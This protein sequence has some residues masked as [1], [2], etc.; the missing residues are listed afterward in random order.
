MPMDFS[1]M[2]LGTQYNYN[3]AAQNRKSIYDDMMRQRQQQDAMALADQQSWNRQ[4]ETQAEMDRRNKYEL[5]SAN[6]KNAATFFTQ[7]MNDAQDTGNWESYKQN[8][9][10][11]QKM[12]PDQVPALTPETESSLKA[13]FE[14]AASVKKM[15]RGASGPGDLIMFES[16]NPGFT[17]EKR[18]TPEYQQAYDAWVGPYVAKRYGTNQFVGT[19]PNDPNKNI[20][21]NTRTG[22]TSI[23]AGAGPAA[24]KELTAPTSEETTK[25][26]GYQSA[27]E[28]VGGLL[29]EME[30]NPNVVSQTGPFAGRWA[31]LTSK[32]KTNEDFIKN[33]AKLGTIMADYLRTT[34]GLTVTDAERKYIEENIIGNMTNE[35]GNLKARLEEFAKYLD[36]QERIYRKSLGEGYR[37]V[38]QSTPTKSGASVSGESQS[39]EQIAQKIRAANPGLTPE[40]QAELERLMPEL[41]RQTKSNM[42]VK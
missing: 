25:L 37:A 28:T 38:K 4:L 24:P 36:R 40:R 32:F 9:L 16:L 13:S 42:G 41:I 3:V 34:S 17:Q 27:R 11:L 6:R 21:Y 2:Q 26:A 30:T 35:P 14:Q 12:I 23:R 33:R 10:A 18:G 29:L 20:T 8:Y 15:S 7:R 19:D 1:P 22:E 39:D 31:E 5:E